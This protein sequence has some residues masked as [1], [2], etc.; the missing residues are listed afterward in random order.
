EML[1]FPIRDETEFVADLNYEVSLS[2]IFAGTTFAEVPIS[3]NVLGME[4][5]EGT[6]DFTIP[7]NALANAVVTGVI[8]VDQSI[9]I[10]LDARLGFRDDV[11]TVTVIA[12][13]NIHDTMPLSL[14]LPI[15][16]DTT[17]TLQEAV[18]VSTATTLQLSD[19]TM[20]NGQLNLTFPQGMEIPLAI[21]LDILVDTEFNVSMDVTNTVQFPVDRVP[22]SIQVA[23]STSVDIFAP[24][25]QQTTTNLTSDLPLVAAA[26][27]APDDGSSAIEGQLNLTFPVGTEFS[28]VAEGSTEATTDIPINI[29]I[30][31]NPEDIPDYNIRDGFGG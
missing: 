20:I 8:S 31:T 14:F 24:I 19:G 23:D 30:P 1:Y 27:F 13:L 3:F 28:I 26:R 29:T 16:I 12:G 11:D 10:A 17:A 5:I 7:E 6:V 9:P 18:T 21:S 15:Q 22:P 4:P 2:G 25:D